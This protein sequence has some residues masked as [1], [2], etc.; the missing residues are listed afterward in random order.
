MLS[1]L[2][3]IAPLSS[4]A[5]LAAATFLFVAGFV[6]Y[7]HAQ[8]TWRG[9]GGRPDGVAGSGAVSTLGRW[10]VVCLAVAFLLWGVLLG[11]PTLLLV[12]LGSVAAAALGIGLAVRV[13]GRL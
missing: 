9:F 6:A 13:L 10:A 5:M 3:S 1:K 8:L 7:S 4:W 2:T 12:V 11:W